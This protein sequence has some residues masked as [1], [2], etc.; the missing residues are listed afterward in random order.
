MGTK[1][2]SMKLKAAN[3]VTITKADAKGPQ[4]L[5]KLSP[6]V[7]AWLLHWVS[8]L[9]V[10]FLLATS[11]ASGLGITSR[12]FPASWMDSHLSAGVAL[13]AV[14]IVRLKTSKPFRGFAHMFTFSMP[15][16]QAVKSALFLV[17][18]VVVISGLAIFQKPPFGR[19][20]VL[21]G[22]FPMP[23]LIRLDHSI[24]Y[25]IIDIHIVLSSI[26]AVFLIAHIIAGLQRTRA[27]GQSRL[28]IMLWPWRKG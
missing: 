24:H 5:P 15:D 19:S 6:S 17:V 2:N 20:G 7:V 9:L 21:F 16:A 22:L 3:P 27:G 8:A 23:T 10:L 12:F 11:L 26:I 4:V 28:A 1:K 14:S 25:V 13:L 18:L